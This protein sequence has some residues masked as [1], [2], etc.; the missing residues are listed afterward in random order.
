MLKRNPSC[1]GLQSNLE[2]LG[3][4]WEIHDRI[5]RLKLF[6]SSPVDHLLLPAGFLRELLWQRSQQPRRQ[7]SSVWKALS[8]NTPWPTLQPKWAGGCM[9]RQSLQIIRGCSTDPSWEIF[10]S[11]LFSSAETSHPH[12]PQ[13]YSHIINSYFPVSPYPGTQLNPRPV[14]SFCPGHQ[15]ITRLW[16]KLCI[17]LFI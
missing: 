3:L 4:L 17:I 14:P 7:R 9:P 15:L 6:N 13:S 2:E 12:N 5:H 8:V 10:W 16:A 1:P 11:I